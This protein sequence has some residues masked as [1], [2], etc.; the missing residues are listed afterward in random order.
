MYL[1]H[2]S[3]VEYKKKEIKEMIRKGCLYVRE[4]YV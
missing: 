2:Q 4:Q 3:V 1:T